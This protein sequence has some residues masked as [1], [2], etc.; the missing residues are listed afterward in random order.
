MRSLVL[1][2]V[3]SGLIMLGVSGCGGP[4]RPTASDESTASSE[5][6][7]G[8]CLINAVN[9]KG[10]CVQEYGCCLKGAT[11][12]ADKAECL[13]D[14]NLCFDDCLAHAPAPPAEC[15]LSDCP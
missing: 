3:L 5:E 15:H 13:T 9:C 7:L 12:P 11:D 2:V 10:I 1:G 8:I 6:A 14:R 4:V